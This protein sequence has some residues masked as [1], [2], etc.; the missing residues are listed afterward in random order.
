M[1]KHESHCLTRMGDPEFS[2]CNCR[3]E[4]PDPTPD[5]VRASTLRDVAAYL[6]WLIEAN[7][8]TGTAESYRL[9]HDAEKIL[10]GAVERACNR[11]E[12]TPELYARVDAM[13]AK[14]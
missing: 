1:S 14:P 8:L 5:E 3:A 7:V 12:L 10:N 2:Y 6:L 9:E 13:K 11:S 4:N